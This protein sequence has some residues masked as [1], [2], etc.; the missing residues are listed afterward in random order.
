MAKAVGVNPAKN[1]L[2]IDKA[3]LKTQG[4][5]ETTTLS[6]DYL[7]LAT[8]ARHSYFGHDDW[9]PFA[10]G[11]K[12][13]EDATNIRRKVLLAFEQAEIETDEAAKKRCLT[14]VMVGG[15]PTGVE[16]AGSIAELARRALAAEFRHIDPASSRILLLEAG[17]RVLAAFPE[18]LSRKAERSL[19]KLGVEVRCNSRVT[20]VDDTGVHLGSETIESKNV[21][22]TAGVVASDAGK[23]LSASGSAQTD[24]AG[25]VKVGGDLSVPGF[26][27][28]FVV[29]DTAH[30]VDRK[31]KPLPGVA[32]VAMQQGT[33][34]AKVIAAEAAQ[35]LRRGTAIKVRTP[36]AYLDKGN[37]ATIGRSSAVADIRNLQLS[38]FVAWLTWIVV[39]IF[40]LIGFR[41]RVFVLLEWVWAYITFQRGTRLITLENQPP[42]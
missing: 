26:R 2:S 19:T 29:G 25:R 30:A 18:G 27:N 36:F 24:P 38:G 7:V 22:W 6:Y 8:G 9:E 4:K 28:L 37:L 39:H 33:Y 21:I 34:V 12:S 32:P 13:I 10:P 41:N 35:K 15:G 20:K 31:G 5:S 17:P 1:E 11:L 16:M 40:Y 23:W 3:I 42:K 14:F